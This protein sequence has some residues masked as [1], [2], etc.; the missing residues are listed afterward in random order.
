MGFVGRRLL[1]SKRP[2]ARMKKQ[3]TNF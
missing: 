1:S 3:I 2:V